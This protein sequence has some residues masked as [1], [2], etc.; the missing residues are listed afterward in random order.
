MSSTN[1]CHKCKKKFEYPSDLKRHLE[2]KNPCDKKV[3]NIPKLFKCPKCDTTFTI[4]GNLDRHIIKFCKYKN[5]DILDIDNNT[6][7]INN[8]QNEIKCKYCGR[9]FT[10]KDSLKKHT[11]LRCKLNITSEVNKKQITELQNI[12][13]KLNINDD[14][15]KIADSVENIKKKIEEEKV[16]IDE[17]Y[18]HNILL[19]N[20]N[21]NKKKIKSVDV[22]KSVDIN[23]I[24]LINC[25]ST[26]EVGPTKSLDL[27]DFGEENLNV[28]DDNHI[29]QIIEKG[30]YSIPEFIKL[31]H[32]SKN[33]NHNCNI[34]LIDVTSKN[35]TIFDN[36]K[37]IDRDCDFII[38]ELFENT[39]NFLL[40]RIK[41]IINNR[42]F[43]NI[44]KI[45]AEFRLI[46]D[47]IE[48]N[49]IKR[50]KILLEIKN[51]IYKLC[52]NI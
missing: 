47:D 48:N 42:N 13:D 26:N 12:I 16:I 11:D 49:L 41:N 27:V 33:M 5:E 50:N 43:A 15:S 32:F 28:F 20:K 14:N 25:N 30:Y 36:N 45:V 23:E 22:I 34:Y 19:K 3:E 44:N 2:R 7:I 35:I 17:K 4:K 6:T 1:K 39:K 46:T 10:R 31:V 24:E 51:V 37:W 8:K 18:R 40:G 21:K 29:I 38:N 9:E 52:H